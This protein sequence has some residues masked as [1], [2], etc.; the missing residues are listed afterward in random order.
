MASASSG[1]FDCETG[2]ERVGF[3]AQDD[4]YEEGIKPAQPSS[5][6]D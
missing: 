6:R 5:S 1:S 2:V 3:S 4:S